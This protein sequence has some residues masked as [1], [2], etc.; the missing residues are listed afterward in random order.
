VTRDKT[1]ED[2]LG[3]YTDDLLTDRRP[4][5]QDDLVSLE[6]PDR[7]D[8]VRLAALVRRLKA[9]HTEAPVPSEDF[10]ARLDTTVAAEVAARGSAHAPEARTATRPQR[11]HRPGRVLLGKIAEF[12]VGWRWQLAACAAVAALLLLQVQVVMQVRRLQQENRNLSARVERL[13]TP[14]HMVPTG[15]PVEI[16]LRL[17]IEQRIDEL[18]KERTVKTGEERQSVERALQEL[19]ALVGSTPGK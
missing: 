4:R 8:V 15:L 1:P 18:E 13:I 3:K 7:A 12:V 19:R 6:G 10:V 2:L 9:A 16:V 17:R 5:L 14:E 11:S